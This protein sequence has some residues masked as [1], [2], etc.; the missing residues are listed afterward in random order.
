[1]AGY[2]NLWQ[3]IGGTAMLW[4]MC[5]WENLGPGIHVNVNLTGNTKLNT[6]TDQADPFYCS[7]NAPKVAQEQFEENDKEFKLLTPGLQIPQI[8]GQSRIC[9]ICM[10]LIHRGLP[11]NLQD[12]MCCSCPGA[13]YH[14]TFRGVLESMPQCVSAV[15]AV[16][17]GLT[18]YY[19][20]DF[21]V[22]VNWAI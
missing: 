21:N 17:G 19:A 22:T 10:T 4:A 7:G 8:S 3:A 15:L 1:M 20:G 18:Q 16:Q 6:E 9:E 5:C 11:C 2:V 12:L 14:S 13:R